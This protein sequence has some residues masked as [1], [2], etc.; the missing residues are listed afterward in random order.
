MRESAGKCRHVKAS[1]DKC[2]Q[3][4]AVV[5]NVGA[6]LWPFGW[7]IPILLSILS[8]IRSLIRT[9]EEPLNEFYSNEEEIL[10]CM[11]VQQCYV[12]CTKPLFSNSKHTATGKKYKHGKPILDWPRY[13][14]LLKNPQFLPN[15]A[16]I[17]V[18]LSTH[19]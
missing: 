14:L 3:V 17:Q 11:M 18:I 19:G 4:K 16:D 5:Y 8:F 2:R 15:Q 12:H 10:L 13:W 7:N 9:F 6:L 1:A